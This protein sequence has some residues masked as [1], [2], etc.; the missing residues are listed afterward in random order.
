MGENA[1]ALIVREA[2]ESDAEA[3][4]ALYAHYVRGSVATFEEAAPCADEIVT[5]M[6]AVQARG[7]PWLAGIDPGGSLAGY[8]YASPYRTR[9]AYRYTVESSVYVAPESVGRGVGTALMLELIATCT[10]AGYRQMLAVIGDRA[11][12]ASIRLHAHLGFEHVGVHRDV[13]FKLGRWID[14]VHMQLA[15]GA[16]GRSLPRL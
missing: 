1:G 5:R 2:R 6:R 8:A 13:G 11:N 7:L 15:L 14:V 10:A 3:I 4:A 16:G 12:A 9:P